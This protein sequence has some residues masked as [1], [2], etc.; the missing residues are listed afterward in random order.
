MNDLKVFEG[1]EVEVLDYNGKILFNPKQIAKCLE[2]GDSGLRNHLSEMN[3]FKRF[4]LKNSDVLLKDF[5]KLNNAGEVFITESGVYDLILKSRKSSAIKFK[6]WITEEVLPSIRKHG[7]YMTP[8]TIEESLTNPDFIIQLATTL[9]EEQNKRKQAELEINR[10][11]DVIEGLTE[12]IPL[13]EKRARLNSIIRYGSVNKYQERY[14]LLYSEFNKV[15]H[16]DIQTRFKNAK[17]RKEIKPNYKNTLDYVDRKLNMIGEMYDIACKL[18]ESDV[19]K[20]VEEWK[21]II[22]REIV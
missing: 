7:A 21:S 8:K 5:R 14:R 22:V 4:K 13:A 15:Y 12:D 11:Q 20:L 10:K 3:D 16:M 17:E 2:I 6:D 9:K 19:E 18:F 1:K